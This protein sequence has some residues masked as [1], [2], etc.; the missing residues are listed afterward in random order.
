[1][2]N[3]VTARALLPLA[4]LLLVGC[5]T[6]T[7]VAVGTSSAAP[8]S[9]PPR[10][11]AYVSGQAIMDQDLRIKLFE[12]AGGQ[13][14]AESV[15]DRAIKGRLAERGMLVAQDDLDREMTYVLATLSHDP[16]QAARLLIDL[17][18][19]RGLGEQRFEAMLFR[20]AGLRLIV[21]DQV[22]L[23]P[24][25]LR[26]AYQLQHGERYRVRIIVTDSIQQATALQVRVREGE[27]FGELAAL[28]S[29]DPSAAQGGLL[30]PISPADLTYPKALRDAL[31]G[32]APGE[33]S[34]LIA[35]D[36]RFIIM[37]LEESLPADSIAFEAVREELERSVRLDAEGQLMRRAARAM[38]AEATVV[39]L[40][41]ALNKSWRA[42]QAKAQNE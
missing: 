17:R 32:L 22:Q 28:H 4:F 11:L 19:E 7:P 6:A 10:P 2:V 37:K 15:L 5:E 9:A 14:L 38:L 3:P 27:P 23:T 42:E 40:D 30:S 13:V 39:V 29:A 16:A 41:P 31:G 1:M 35:A 34:D 36:Q 26:R 24:G 25:L 8:R 33:V 12:A 21:Q 18:A 20:N